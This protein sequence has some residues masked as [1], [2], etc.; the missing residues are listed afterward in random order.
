[1]PDLVAVGGLRLEGALTFALL[2]ADAEVDGRRLESA[3]EVGE[4]PQPVRAPLPRRP[5]EADAAAEL[6]VGLLAGVRLA[7]GPGGLF[8]ALALF[9][10]LVGP[11]PR[12]QPPGRHRVPFAQ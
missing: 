4:Q 5:R 11:H 3:A 10:R 8:L 2:L 6:G 12:L 1:D 7:G 9:D